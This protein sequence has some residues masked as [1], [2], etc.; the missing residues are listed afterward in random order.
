MKTSRTEFV[1][2]LD[3][4]LTPE[5]AKSYLSYVD[6]LS[7]TVGEESDYFF[8]SSDKEEALQLLLNGGLKSNNAFA[9]YSKKFQSNIRTGV[10][11]LIKFYKEV[12]SREALKSVKVT[13]IDTS[14]NPNQM[15]D[16]YLNKFGDWLKLR[17]VKSDG[18]SFK[19]VKNYQL[20][21]RRAII[22][23]NID[24][25]VFFSY[26]SYFHLHAFHL[27]VKN[28]K[29]FLNRS[30]SVRR[31]INSSINKYK[32]YIAELHGEKLKSLF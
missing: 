7:R 20:G 6:A 29:N 27:N 3:L 23:L 15:V 1:Q 11:A 2:F 22:D 30:E 10:R 25:K 19:A 8:S 32:V 5:S 24:P 13:K 26:T 21:I 18:D 17:H 31:E 16:H 9:N 12:K 14:L 28:S 4:R